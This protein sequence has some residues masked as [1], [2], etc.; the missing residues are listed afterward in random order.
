MRQRTDKDNGVS[1]GGLS[2]REVDPDRSS[3]A[4]M[5]FDHDSLLQYFRHALGDNASQNVGCAA[6]RKRHHEAQV[7]IGERL[8]GGRLDKVAM[9]VAKR[10]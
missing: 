8:R 3:C 5:V 6:G 10:D 2:R 9:R 1:V 7:M 4:T